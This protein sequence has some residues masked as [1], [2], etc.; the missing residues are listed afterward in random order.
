M[1]IYRSVPEH[2]EAVTPSDT[3]SLGA[4]STIYIGGAGNIKVVT[5]GGDTVTF[6]GVLAGIFLPVAV[7]Q[8][9]STGTT[10]TNM[11]ACF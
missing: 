3:L 11:V 5:T 10:A 2:A 7:T 6:N 4:T 9:F 1:G 8:V